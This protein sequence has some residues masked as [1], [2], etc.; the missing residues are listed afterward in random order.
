[1]LEKNIQKNILSW[2]KKNKIMYFKTHQTGFTQSGISDIIGCL[3]D[4]RFFALEV[5]TSKGKPTRLQ[6]H[7]LEKVDF[8]DGI[9][10]IVRSVE[11]VERLFA[12]HG[13]MFV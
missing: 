5:K 3:Y 11:D 1:M 13:Y 4:G 7:F 8:N 10:G 6:T 2:L 9:N 12:D